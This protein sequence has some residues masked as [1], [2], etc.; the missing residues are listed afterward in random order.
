MS[1]EQ[2]VTL[3]KFIL[4]FLSLNVNSVYSFF[5]TDYEYHKKII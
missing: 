1:L 4:R 5:V 2:L 3:L